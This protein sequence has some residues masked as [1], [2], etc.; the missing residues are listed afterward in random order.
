MHGGKLVAGGR[1][2]QLPRGSPAPSP[3]G[4][5]ARGQGLNRPERTLSWG[6]LRLSMRVLR[7]S[8]PLIKTHNPSPTEVGLQPLEGSSGVKPREVTWGVVLLS[9]KP[10][11][12]RAHTPRATAQASSP[13]SG[14]ASAAAGQSCARSE[15][16]WN[17]SGSCPHPWPAGPQC[18]SACRGLLLERPLSQ[19]TVPPRRELGGAGA[20]TR[21]LRTETSLGQMLP[22]HA[23]LRAA[24]CSS[25]VR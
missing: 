3:P 17:Q 11:E 19:R 2:H 16:L 15:H 8:Y 14:L 23:A 5:Q 7:L 10:Q 18:C 22:P 9:L 24:G 6:F 1:S 20:E 25:L 4:A 13:R 12:H 21:E